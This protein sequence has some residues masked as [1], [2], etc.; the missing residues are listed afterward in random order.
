MSLPQSPP[1]R[2]VYSRTA[3]A[4]R[5]AGIRALSMHARWCALG[6]AA[7]LVIA[8]ASRHMLARSGGGGGLAYLPY[9]PYIGQRPGE[10]A[11]LEYR[12]FPTEADE[13]QE[14]MAALNTMCR[15]TD[16]AEQPFVHVVPQLYTCAAPLAPTGSG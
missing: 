13:L 16:V 9:L 15:E 11:T 4:V 8:A 1:G 7:A 14:M 10:R 12:A 3:S 6:T 2:N 5:R